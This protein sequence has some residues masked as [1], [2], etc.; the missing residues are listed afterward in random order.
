MDARA[1]APDLP[2]EM[3]ETVAQGLRETLERIRAAADR[4][5]REPGCVHLLAVSKMQPAEKIRAAFAAGQRAFGENYPQESLVKIRLLAD[6]GIEWH[7]IGRVQS[8]KTRAIAE[9]F[10]WLHSLCDLHHARRISEQRPENL[11][12]LRACV[13]VNIDRESTKAGLLPEDVAPFLRACRDLPRLTLCGLMTLPAPTQNEA[14]QR[15]PFR[16]LRELRDRLATPELPL[17]TLSMGT[18]DD[19]EA[20]I[21][22]GATIV[23]IGTAVFGPR[24]SD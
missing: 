20:A 7:F 2:M 13:Q 9:H 6:L 12:P 4:C 24:P 21:A 14:A 15:V 3:T 8:N 23:R 19:F 1:V 18:S 16:A 22:E 5:A 10:A 17:E 11:P